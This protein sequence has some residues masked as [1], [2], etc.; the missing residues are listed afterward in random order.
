M[1]IR[2]SIYQRAK[3]FILKHDKRSLIERNHLETLYHEE[4]PIELIE[5]CETIKNYR[6]EAN[7]LLDIGAH[8][9]LFTKVASAFFNFKEAVCFEPNSK[10]NLTIAKVNSK[11]NCTIENI[12][13]SNREGVVTFY[14]HE[15]DAMNSTVESNN[16]L[17]KEEFPWDN[18]DKIQSTM[19]PTES[20]DS[21]VQRKGFINDSFFIK[22]DTQGNELDVLKGA[23]NTLKS[24]EICLVE[25]MFFTPYRSDF[26]FFDFVNFMESN[27][28][29]CKGAL[30][31]SKRPSKKV[32]AVDL[33]F[34]KRR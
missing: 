18:P 17:L 14:L 3:S 28:F 2:K 7:V 22:L 11:T 21:Y 15:D 34:V 6:N 1:N 27:N 5:M 32:S 16:K 29:D 13:L 19:V 25:Y 30:S 33:L 20:L 10:L 4:F 24:T 31:I 23:I 26:T 8:K 12:A 9:G